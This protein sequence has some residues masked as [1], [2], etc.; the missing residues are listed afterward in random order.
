[1]QGHSV[2]WL[3]VRD[4]VY[5]HSNLRLADKLQAVA[6]NEDNVSWCCTTPEV[7][8]IDSDTDCD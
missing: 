5:V 7:E 3:Q 6:Y 1:V 2:I 4:I 8:I